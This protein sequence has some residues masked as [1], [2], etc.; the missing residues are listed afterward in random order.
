METK[1]GIQIFIESYRKIKEA[2][3]KTQFKD[4][5]LEKA[6]IKRE[7]FVTVLQLISKYNLQTAYPNLYNLYKILVALPIGST[8]CERSFSRLKIVKSR[9]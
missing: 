2:A 6:D 7:N 1:S 3:S 4:L 9:L 5:C 8:K